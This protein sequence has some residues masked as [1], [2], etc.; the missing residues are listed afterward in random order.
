M[1]KC[2]VDYTAEEWARIRE[3]AKHYDA[4]ERA[5]PERQA[6]MRKYMATYMR[7][8]QY[9]KN[10]N[11]RY[12]APR[13]E[14]QLASQRKRRYGIT[15]QQVADLM[16]FQEGRCAVCRRKFD[17]HQGRQT[18]H[19]A[20]HCHDTNQFRGLLCRMCNTFEGFLR[21]LGVT[22]NEFAKRLQ[23]Y[24]DNPPASEVIW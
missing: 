15:R 14:A 7:T 22:P 8:E 24:L 9:R 16:A 4:K 5:K 13:R 12:G 10:D 18:L 23:A 21:G 19:C 17:D 11:A 1:S 20:D 6:Y 2:K 3:R